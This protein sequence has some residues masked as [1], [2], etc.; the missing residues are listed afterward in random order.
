MGLVLTALR[1]L[2]R[3]PTPLAPFSKEDTEGV[4]SRLGS[5]HHLDPLTGPS[6]GSISLLAA[7]FSPAVGGDST[8]R[9]GLSP[10]DVCLTS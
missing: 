5:E 3:P 1:C 10:P 8:H 4:S 9:V 6:G 2:P 7:T